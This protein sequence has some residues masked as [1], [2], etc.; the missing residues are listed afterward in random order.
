ME[1]RNL[2]SP[3]RTLS[4]TTDMSSLVFELLNA[5]TKTHLAHL[6]VTGPGSFASHKALNDFYEGVKSLA[7]DLAEQYQ[8][9]TESLLIAP[10]EA[11]FPKM[12]KTSECISYLRDLRARVNS[13]QSSCPYSEICNTLDEVKSLIN[14]TCYKLI[15]LQ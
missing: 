11:S 15:F 9:V 4:R 7:D 1:N 10:T 8:G 12:T 3:I 2:K 14:S 6:A 5:S 13:A